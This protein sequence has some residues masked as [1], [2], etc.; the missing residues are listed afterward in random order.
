MTIL[1]RASVDNRSNRGGTVGYVVSQA[2]AAAF[3]LEV[4]V[5]GGAAAGALPLLSAL[6][7]GCNS[8]ARF[9]GGTEIIFSSR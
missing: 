9:G 3:A 1:S 5:G 7:G 6:M 2:A 8:G 4:S